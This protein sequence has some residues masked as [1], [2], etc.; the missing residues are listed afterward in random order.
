MNCP[1][2]GAKVNR[3][4]PFDEAIEREGRW[5]HRFCY[6]EAQERKERIE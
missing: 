3:D 4:D 5:W 6:R 1:E 2:C